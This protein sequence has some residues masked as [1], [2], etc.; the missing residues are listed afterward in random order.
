[1]S[2]TAV[3]GACWG[4]EGKGKIVDWLA[5]DA[6]YVVRF[7]GGRNAGHTIVNEWGRVSLHLLPSGVF[8]HDVVNVIGPGVAVDIAALLEELED[9]RSRGI[10]D[11]TLWISERAQVVLPFHREFDV[12]EERRRGSARFGS[13]QVGIAPFY[14][15]KA[16]KLGIQVADLFDSVRLR[17][18]IE[19]SLAGKNI[20]LR[21]L[22]GT[23]EVEIDKLIPSL[24]D[25]GRAI[26][27][28]VR[29]TTTMLLDAVERDEEI[30]LE[31]QLG[32]LRDPDHGV[33]PF[34]T[35][36]SPVAGYGTVGAGVPPTAYR[37]IVA[38]VKAYS[39][40]VGATPFVSELSGPEAE[41]LRQRGGEYGSTT[42]RPRR[43]GWFD[44]VAARYGCR[45][46]GATEVALMLLDVL[47]PC[48]EI[49]ICTA[50]EIDGERTGRFPTCERLERAVPVYESMPGW[51]C[52]LSHVRLYSDLP[53]E[54]RR[55]VERI[56]ELIG[57][58][59]S[60]ISVGP[61]RDAVIR[62]DAAG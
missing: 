46:Q 31:G 49:P 62:R 52:D 6:D 10:P 34:T 51:M 61:E 17:R 28:F 7:Q 36:S 21:H 27:P 59:I 35:S 55:Y 39:S 53:E 47:D 15:D 44:A 2:V 43:V 30:L 50:Y 40:C 16:L 22:Y 48:S 18:R 32:A 13:T 54:A 26:R 24:L 60:T 20:L 38:V 45:V 56:E 3:V 9:L 37:R 33:Y 23:G 41:A 58:R 57:V 14:S 8:R 4:D 25:L 5:A 11:P 42:G 19:D 1:M 29:D 12:L